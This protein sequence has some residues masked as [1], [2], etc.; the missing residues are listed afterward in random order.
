MI[1]LKDELYDRKPCTQWQFCVTESLDDLTEMVIPLFCGVENKNVSVPE[2]L[3]PPYG[4]EES[5]VTNILSILSR[6]ANM[7][8]F[9]M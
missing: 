1:Y 7:Y 9:T 3:D 4:V 2:W 8:S 5:K 6:K